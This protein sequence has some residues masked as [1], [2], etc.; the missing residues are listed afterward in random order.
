[1]RSF[2]PALLNA[3]SRPEPGIAGRFL[4]NRARG[5]LPVQRQHDIVHRTGEPLLDR[6]IVNR[7]A[8]LVAYG[9]IALDRVFH[10]NAIGPLASVEGLV[11]RKVC[12]PER[13][14]E[15]TACALIEHGYDADELQPGKHGRE[16]IEVLVMAAVL[17][18]RRVADYDVE[19][20]RVGA[21]ASYES[22]VR[23]AAPGKRRRSFG[24]YSPPPAPHGLPIPGC[25]LAPSSINP[26]R[27]AIAFYGRSWI[28]HNSFVIR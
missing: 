1:M 3:F 24:A 11:R 5:C 13:V 26:S 9:A 28:V 4:S 18:D 7:P 22:T 19:R 15:H 27:K 10:W 17:P 20:S 25:R 16:K 6:H 21:G 2:A 14:R 23:T 12:T 8:C